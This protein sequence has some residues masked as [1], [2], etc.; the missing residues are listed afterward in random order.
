MATAPT[1][2]G[3]CRPVDGG[4]ALRVRLTPK[5]SRDEVAGTEATAEGP[6]IKARVRAVPE[7]G[8][9]NAALETLVAKWLGVAKG[10]VAVTAGT[11]SRVKRVTVTGDSQALAALVAARLQ[12]V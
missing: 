3:L 9:A 12:L 5:S 2:E 4:V 8:E 11:K 6:A 10:S 7:D 1:S